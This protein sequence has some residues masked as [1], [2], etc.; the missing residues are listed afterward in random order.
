[1]L[2]KNL[3]ASGGG[4]WRRIA[5]ERAF[6]AH[7]LNLPRLR[8]AEP[9][10]ELLELTGSHKATSRPSGALWGRLMG[11]SRSVAGTG[12]FSLQ[13]PR[14]MLVLTP[15]FYLL[16]QVESCRAAAGGDVFFG[17][18]MPSPPSR[19]MPVV[20]LVWFNPRRSGANSGC[21]RNKRTR[22]GGTDSSGIPRA[23]GRLSRGHPS[24]TLGLDAQPSPG[25]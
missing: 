12:A 18:A 14:Y 11:C 23:A 20:Q 5:P 9:R 24:C 1:M 13:V 4:C 25:V 8:L 15:V 19:T 2:G 3:P 22:Q 21:R 17:S 10:G 6:C 16:S 7:L